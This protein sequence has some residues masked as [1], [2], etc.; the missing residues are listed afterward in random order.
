MH[1]AFDTRLIWNTFWVHK[2]YIC[3]LQKSLLT[4]CKN[5]QWDVSSWTS[6]NLSGW[7]PRRASW[8]DFCTS[9]PFIVEICTRQEASDR[10]NILHIKRMCHCE[11]EDTQLV[12]CGQSERVECSQQTVVLPGVDVP[13]PS[14]SS[15]LTLLPCCLF[16]RWRR[17]FMWGHHFLLLQPGCCQRLFFLRLRAARL[18]L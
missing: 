18:A 15:V 13:P 6:L 7:W 3:G 8:E 5:I 11:A 4:G 12:I 2:E 17:C 9:L 10:T 16:S 1:F 14:L